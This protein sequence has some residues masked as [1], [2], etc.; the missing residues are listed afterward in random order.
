MFACVV[1]PLWVY[2]ARPAANATSMRAYWMCICCK[3]RK[4]MYLRVRVYVPVCVCTYSY[5]CIYT[6][7]SVSSFL[8]KGKKLYGRSCV[9]V[10]VFKKSNHLCPLML[11]LLLA[12]SIDGA[13]QPAASKCQSSSAQQRQRRRRQQQQQQPWQSC[14]SCCC[15]CSSIF[16]CFGRSFCILEIPLASVQLES[17]SR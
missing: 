2:C 10:C 7:I 6:F 14:R 12:P 4:S 9:C 17:S 1:L 15:C 13:G 3:S 11:L 5:N 8:A 16:I